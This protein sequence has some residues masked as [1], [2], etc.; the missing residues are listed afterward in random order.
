LG[1]I[2]N[3]SSWLNEVTFERGKQWLAIGLVSAFIVLPL[4]YAA[5]SWARISD[6]S[7]AGN[8]SWQSLLF[9]EWEQITGVSPTVGLLGLA[10]K[11][12]NQK[13]NLHK[14]L[15]RLTEFTYFIPWF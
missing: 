5:K 4:L 6:E 3:R 1:I 2:A 13:T 8:F 14:N 15:A 9:A 10:Q 12:L 11:K 7:L